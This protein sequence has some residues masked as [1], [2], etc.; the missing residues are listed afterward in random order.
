MSVR[1]ISNISVSRPVKAHVKCLYPACV[2]VSRSLPHSTRGPA[3]F[4]SELRWHSRDY[5]FSGRLP[6]GVSLSERTLTE[7]GGGGHILTYRKST[8]FPLAE[9]SN[10][11]NVM[12]FGLNSF[13]VVIAFFLSSG[14]TLSSRKPP[15]NEDKTN[16]FA[17]TRR[18]THFAS[19]ERTTCLQSSFGPYFG[20]CVTDTQRPLSAAALERTSRLS[21]RP[22]PSR[23]TGFRT[24]K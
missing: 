22:T 23:G 13:F 18:A 2:F 14:E 6:C 16:D 1:I 9:R 17:A 4:R 24:R 20:P 10:C 8:S 7:Q 3:Y 5:L 15:R 12:D 11:V 19:Y 21:Q